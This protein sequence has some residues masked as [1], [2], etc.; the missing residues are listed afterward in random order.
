M[1]VFVAILLLTGLVSC[2]G[3]GKAKVPTDGADED[4]VAHVAVTGIT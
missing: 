2:S 3:T 4:V 1:R